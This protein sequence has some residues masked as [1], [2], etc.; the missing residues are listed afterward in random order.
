[1]AEV[2]LLAH[3]A[4]FASGTG[5]GSAKGILKD[6]TDKAATVQAGVFSVAAP[7]V[8][9]ADKLETLQDDILRDVGVTFKEGWL[10]LLA[11]LFGGGTRADVAGK[12][13]NGEQQGGH[14]FTH[15]FGM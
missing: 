9:D 7:A 11:G 6:Q 12:N 5:Q 4:H 15:N 10:F 2:D 14:Y 1:M 8:T 13:G 3:F